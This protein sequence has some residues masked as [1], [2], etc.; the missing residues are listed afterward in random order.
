VGDLD[1]ITPMASS[2]VEKSGARP[3]ATEGR[4]AAV[5]YNPVKV[6]AADLK[7]VVDE[8]RG[9]AGWKTL[10]FE[11]TED[12]PGGGQ[13]RQALDAGATLVI[14]AGG[15][16]TVREVAEVLKGTEVALCLLPSGTGNL[17]ARNLEL[18][19]D[20]M[21]HSI[22][23]A[24]AGSERRVDVA[25]MSIS[26]EDG[27]VDELAFL[28]MGG[29]GLD[30]KIM[31]NTDEDLKAKVG[32]LAYAKALFST[33]RTRDALR[34]RYRLDAGRTHSTRAEA[35]IVG[36][37]GSLPA[38]I[39]LLPDAVVDDGF[40][41]VVVLTP[42]RIRGWLG[43]I[44]KIFLENGIVKRIGLGRK[45]AGLD[46]DAVDYHQVKALHVEL[47]RAEQIELD[48]DP[49]G[50]AVSFECRIEPQALLLRVPEKAE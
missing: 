21:E 43:L 20:D 49:F 24:Y 45:K 30:A 48:G 27:S 32:W 22:H 23:T 8:E 15:D 5:I 42:E 7:A 44:V 13:A 28:V 14:A 34:L 35:I 11:T 38:K 16:G 12:D 3:V 41:D 31:S 46:V 26:R 2:R 37:C 6:E 25:V 33:L 29:V 40:L 9:A 10:W 17:F 1:N 47:S 4:I 18:T 36:N 19:L 50:H 39:L